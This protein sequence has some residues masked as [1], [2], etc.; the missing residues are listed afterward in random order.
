MSQTSIR[1]E[2]IDA[3][4][5]IAAIV[6]VLHHYTF[7]YSEVVGEHSPGLLFVSKNGHFGVNL[8]FII[9][10]F[11][12]FMSLERSRRMADFIV[13]RFARLWPA[14]LACACVTTTLIAFTHFNPNQ[15]TK[16]DALLNVLMMNKVLG[17]VAIDGSYW[18]LTYE[19]LFY[20]GA[21]I[22][23]FALRI[24][25]MEWPCLIWLAVALIAR[26]S[27][28]NDHHLRLGVLLGVDYCHLFILGMMIYVFWQ[29]RNTWLTAT[30]AVLAYSMTMFG[31]L[32]NPGNVRLWQYMLMTL[33]FAASVWLIA[34]RRLR[35]LNI[36]PLL[37][38]GEIS[39]SL[40]LVHQVAGYWV[41]SKLEGWGWGSNLA[42]FLTIL[43]AIL[44]A[45]GVRR[46][47]EVPM[48]R[49]IRD[50]Y[51]KQPRLYLGASRAAHVGLR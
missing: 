51:K 45:T 49:L 8:F 24:R 16:K 36:W 28:F 14:Y 26:L 12:I 34:E 3:L 37:F 42:I 33:V 48:Q 15:L 18:T 25:R 4:R 29:R 6:V 7:R 47:V 46:W 13:S 5:G 9:S 41:I 31:P 40:Y 32:Y 22:V 50:Q 30:T 2:G 38:L 43:A 10:G 21:A 20:A 1:L 19:V 11:V 35:F 23:F 17:N 39:Y 44:V 27:G